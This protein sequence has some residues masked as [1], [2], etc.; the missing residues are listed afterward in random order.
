MAIGQQV[1]ATFGSANSFP[2]Q[3]RV[4]MHERIIATFGTNAAAPLLAPCTPVGFNSTTGYYGKWVAPSAAKLVVNTG[5]ATGGNFDFTVNGTAVADVAYN[6]S[7]A[8]IV[9]TLRG[10]GYVAT[11]TLASGVYT[12]TFGDQKD[13][14][15]VP[16][17]TG[18]I[19]DLT[20]D[21]SS[22]A[23]VTAG[24]S[25]YGLNKLVG[26]VWPTE[27][28]LSTT[29]ETLGV[30]MIAGRIEYSDI[31]VASGDAAAL[32]TEIKQTA[33]GRGIIVEDLPNIR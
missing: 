12:I 14:E 8:S 5:G 9:A 13:L 18:D 22:A 25:T 31:P 24:A 29:T 30:V 6:A 20:G 10:L 19:T 17:L 4:S 2:N 21:T 11:V 1:L 23:T 15:I 7:A 28:Q 33:L 26:F 32:A 16:V 3:E 27:V